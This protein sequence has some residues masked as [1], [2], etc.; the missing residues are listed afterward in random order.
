MNITKHSISKL[1]SRF[2]AI[3]LGILIYAAIAPSLRSSSIA[4]QEGIEPTLINPKIT[5]ALIVLT[6]VVFCVQSKLKWLKLTGWLLLFLML[7]L[8]FAPALLI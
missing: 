8:V 6:P 4:L 1:I 2:I 3:I 7:T 5:L